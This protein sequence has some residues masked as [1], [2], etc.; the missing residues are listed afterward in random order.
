MRRKDR[1][2]TDEKHIAEIIHR[3]HC[4]RVGFYDN[5]SV[6]IV[7]MNFGCEKNESG[8]A[9]YFHG[10]KEGRKYELIRKSPD[11]GFELDT[12]YELR[13]AD[14]ACGCSARYQSI[15]GTGNIAPVTDADEKIK[16]LNL[17][18]KH[19]TQKSGWTFDNRQL[20]AVCVYKLNIREI[21][22]KECMR[23]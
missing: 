1:E 2:V 12:G 6:Y 23:I 13:E 17:I 15:I 7:P 5:G 9:F 21:S 22:C 16:A 20:D 3:C 8:Y 4:C 14:T 19:N 10:A 18:M 11:V